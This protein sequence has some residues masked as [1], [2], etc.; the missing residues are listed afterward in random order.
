MESSAICFYWSFNFSFT[1]L[2]QNIS[3]IHFKEM[4]N[5]RTQIRVYTNTYVRRWESSVVKRGG[6]GASGVGEGDPI[7]TSCL[8]QV[9]EAMGGGRPSMDG[10]SWRW[11]S[12]G[13]WEPHILVPGPVVRRGLPVGLL[14]KFVHLRQSKR[15]QWYN[16]QKSLTGL[17]Q[18]AVCLTLNKQKILLP[19]SGAEPACSVAAEPRLTAHQLAALPWDLPGG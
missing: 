11:R 9:G 19:A 5:E 17:K 10:S 3:T 2:E 15:Y 18:W 1:M 13:P 4:C 6:S 16:V 14:G 7:P 12:R 8:C